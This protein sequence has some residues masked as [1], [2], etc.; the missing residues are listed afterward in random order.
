[1]K[2][3]ITNVRPFEILVASCNDVVLVSQMDSG[4]GLTANNALLVPPI[5]HPCT[6]L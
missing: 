1:M 3:Q 6:K 4:D 2:R 5:K